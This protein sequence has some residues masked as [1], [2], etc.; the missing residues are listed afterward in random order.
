M[1]ITALLFVASATAAVAQPVVATR[2]TSKVEQDLLTVLVASEDSRD[3]AFPQ[4]D[5]RRLG[6]ASANRYLRAFTVRGLGR[7]EEPSLIP[8]IASSL[9]DFDAEV[10]AAAADA[11]AGAAARGLAPTADAAT[12]AKSADAATAARNVLHPRLTVERDVT[13]RAALLEAIGRLNQGSVDR[14]KG[15]ARFIAPSLGAATPTERRGAIRGLFFW[16][17]SARPGRRAPYPWR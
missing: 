13:V 4:T 11:I 3:A 1:R 14:V 8:T 9:F 17:E 7:L 12:R 16:L 6:L 15:T 5:P 10:R 2:L